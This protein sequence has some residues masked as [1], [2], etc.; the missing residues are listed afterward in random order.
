[1]PGRRQAMLKFAKRL[2]SRKGQGM[3]EYILIVALIALAAIVAFKY[4]GATLR[5]KTRESAD[6]LATGDT[7]Q[8]TNTQSATMGDVP[9]YA[10]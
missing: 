6:V 10:E 7:S 3:T 4:F 1:M 5:N 2:G 9:D 8:L